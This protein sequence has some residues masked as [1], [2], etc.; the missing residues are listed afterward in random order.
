[1]SRFSECEEESDSNLYMQG[2][3]LNY[4]GFSQTLDA[5]VFGEFLISINFWRFF[6]FMSFYSNR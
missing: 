5:S 6:L 2:D 3:H 1:M 4:P